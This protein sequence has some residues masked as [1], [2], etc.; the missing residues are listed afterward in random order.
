MAAR[1]YRHS[2]RNCV[3]GC[4]FHKK[5]A[6]F[7]DEFPPGGRRDTQA[8]ML[9]FKRIRG[10][11]GIMGIRGIRGISNSHSHSHSH[12]LTITNNGF[13]KGGP[14]RSGSPSLWW[15]PMAGSIIDDAESP[16]RDRCDKSD[17]Q[18]K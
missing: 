11:R 6:V 16:P 3:S 7:G 15:Q 4:G 8:P 5:G 12:S 1:H 2:A 10:I 9:V 17:K 18:D 13:H 14:P